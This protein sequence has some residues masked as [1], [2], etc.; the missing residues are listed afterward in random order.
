MSRSLDVPLAQCAA[1]VQNMIMVQ[2]PQ[3]TWYLI[4]DSATEAT[5]WATAMCTARQN[6]LE[7]LRAAAQSGLA[8]PKGAA[9]TATSRGSRRSASHPSSPS[10]RSALRSRRAAHSPHEAQDAESGT[11]ISPELWS[12]VPPPRPITAGLVLA[13]K[14]MFMGCTEAVRRELAATGK[15]EG[16][17]LRSICWCVLGDALPLAEV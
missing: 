8:P 9:A 6:L 13:F 2:R 14:R 15:L 11:A 12:E 16:V 17:G 5:S 3:R 10:S 7:G 1:R 4:A